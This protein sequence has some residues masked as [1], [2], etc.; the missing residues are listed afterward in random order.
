MHFLQHL[1]RYLLP[2]QTMVIS[3]HPPVPPGEDIRI[4]DA[5][6]VRITDDDSIRITDS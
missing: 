4:T 6:A 5:E 1:L 3:N 2:V